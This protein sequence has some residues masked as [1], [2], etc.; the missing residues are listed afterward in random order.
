MS[1]YEDSCLR[2]GTFGYDVDLVIVIDGSERMAPIIS[3]VK[4]NALNFG[5]VIM[6][7]AEAKA[8]YV[9]NLR[10]KVVVF[11]NYI[12]DGD[13]AMEESKFFTLPEEVEG[14][15]AFVDNIEASGGGDK[16]ESGLE[17]LALAMGSDWTKLGERRRHIIMFFTN[18][19]A[20]SLKDPECM[21]NPAYPENMPDTLEVLNDMW[22][23]NSQSF[24]GMP[25]HNS[26]RLVLFA[27]NDEV[28][29][30]LETWS[31]TWHEMSI[32]ENGLAEMRFDQILRTMSYT[33][34][35]V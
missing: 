3:L 7:E 22:E 33:R 18:A 24:K 26:G 1:I 29:N 4:D 30:R 25:D 21:K 11:R 8:K 5:E 2:A 17:A 10:I 34:Y 35:T 9:N 32:A 16:S 15:K 14:Y 31:R 27:P 28:W 20:I 19:T 13:R 23:G 6:E 12:S